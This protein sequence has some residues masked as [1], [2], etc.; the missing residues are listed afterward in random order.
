[1]SWPQAA[2]YSVI[3][4]KTIQSA[5]IPASIIPAKEGQFS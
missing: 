2:E 5:S 1:M 4:P 3:K